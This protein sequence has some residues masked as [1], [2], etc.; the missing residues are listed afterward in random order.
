MEKA[1]NSSAW[2]EL[3]YDLFAHEGLDGIQV[4]RLA[5]ILQLNKSGFYHY[6][7]DLE[8]FC[9][10]LISLHKKKV[11]LFLQE[12]SITKDL[13]PGYLLLLIAHAKTVMFQVQITRNKDNHLFYHAS[14]KVDRLVDLGVRQLWCEYVGILDNKDVAMR[15]YDIVRDMFYTR[16]TFK[17]LNY[18]FLHDLVSE[19]KLLIQDIA[20]RLA[21]VEA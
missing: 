4:E 7:G 15:Y 2:T 16:V 19:A 10:E 11:T 9:E 1:R 6:F 12:V 5:R 8:G 13:D 3:G 21:V 14:E 17:N 18:P 20:R